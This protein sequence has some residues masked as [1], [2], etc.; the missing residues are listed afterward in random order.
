MGTYIPCVRQWHNVVNI[1]IA[2]GRPRL[3]IVRRSPATSDGAAR[4]GLD[5]GAVTD[6]DTVAR[7]A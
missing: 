4:A 3:P 6:E 1:D 7:V 5:V 2:S